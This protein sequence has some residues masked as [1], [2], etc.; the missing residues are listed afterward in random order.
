MTHLKTTH[1]FIEIVLCTVGPV[2]FAGHV[3]R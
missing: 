1:E 3:I 2:L